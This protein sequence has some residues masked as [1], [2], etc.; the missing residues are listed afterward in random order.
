MLTQTFIEEM[1]R[2]LAEEQSR[3]KAE[4]AAIAPHTELG[5][6]EDDN[7]QEISGDEASLDEIAVLKSDLAKV[8]KA[9][10]KIA[11]GTYGTDD[12]GNEI[13]EERLRALPWADKAL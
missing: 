3:L 2:R 7:A 12:D 9:L 4:L 8:G 11:A 13:S 6:D 1:K 10:E 5:D